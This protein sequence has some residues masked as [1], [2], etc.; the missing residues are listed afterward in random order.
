MVE[1]GVAIAALLA[2]APEVLT[3]GV[4]YTVVAASSALVFGLWQTVAGLTDVHAA[5]SIRESDSG[6][7][8]SC[9]NG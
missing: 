9:H 7:Y 3:I 5:G 8:Q 1:G 4:A 2:A 6:A